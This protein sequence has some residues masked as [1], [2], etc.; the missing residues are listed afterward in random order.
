M[1][2]PINFDKKKNEVSVAMADPLNLEAIEFLERRTGAKVKAMIA[3]EEDIKK[4]IAERYGIGLTTE[5]SAAL[6]EAAPEAEAK[7]IDISR[8]GEVIR[9]AP[10]AKI[11]S[12]VLEFAMRLTSFGYSFEPQEDKTRVRYRIDGILHEKLVLPKMSMML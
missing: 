8:L 11:V 2:I 6:K 3:S 4:A 7:V 1:A 10:I 12:T 5:V 9:E